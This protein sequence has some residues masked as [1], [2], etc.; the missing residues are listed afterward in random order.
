MNT[1][2]NVD[3]ALSNIESTGSAEGN[4][5]PMGDSSSQSQQQ[6]KTPTDDL[7]EYVTKGGKT[8]RESLEMIKKR[9][10]MGYSYAQDMEAFNKE[11]QSLVQ[12]AER[13][14]QLARWEEYNDF[15]E[16][17]PAWA[18]HV[19]QMWDNR[20]SVLQQQGAEDPNSPLH[21]ELQAV[22][23]Q[24]GELSGF[25]GTLKQERLQQQQAAED[26]ALDSEV[27]SI[28]EKYSDI[29]FDLADES[30]KSLEFRIL[31]HGAQNGIKS[32]KTAFHDFYHD[33]L[34]KQ[35]ED[36]AKEQVMKELQAKR[37]A[38]VLGM[39]DAPTRQV[40][41]SQGVRNKTY[42]QLATEAMQELGIR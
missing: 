40:G 21:S 11:K 9:A 20:E 1:E 25:L 2:F 28:R 29:D 27:K 35:R 30:G 19:Q 38:G 36:K 26:K 15:A 10:G 39:T 42:D 17:N 7:I 16:K 33:H 18:Q 41:S 3:T 34:I 22:K 13:A 12:Q 5:A 23:A 8:V 24:I 4:A 31:E 32:F 6:P 14:K 37:K